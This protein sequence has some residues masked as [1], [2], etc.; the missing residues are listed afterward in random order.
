[1][2]WA[3]GIDIERLTYKG[4]NRRTTAEIQR[5]IVEKGKR[6]WVSGILGARGDKDAIAAWKQELVMILDVFNVR[7]LGSVGNSLTA[8][9][10]TELT[11]NTYVAVERVSQKLD[12][13]AIQVES[14][15][16]QHPSVSVTS[17][18]RTNQR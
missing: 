13:L 7:S 4:P 12:G 9:F 10:Q 14:A 1:M 8:P 17:S 3:G 6:H 15:R 18:S 16:C 11:I 2:S 5:N